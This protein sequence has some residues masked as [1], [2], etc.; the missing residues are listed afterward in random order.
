[1]AG[2]GHD[3]VVL[4]RENH[5]TGVVD[6]GGILR[7]GDFEGVWR[8]HFFPLPPSPPFSLYALGWRGCGGATKWRRGLGKALRY[9]GCPSYR[10]VVAMASAGAQPMAKGGKGAC[11]GQMGPLG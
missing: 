7:F 1:V 9:R 8:L 11:V 10:E 3:E 6:Q 4:C 2:Y 5:Y